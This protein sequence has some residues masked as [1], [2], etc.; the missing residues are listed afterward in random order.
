[1]SRQTKPTPKEVVVAHALF[2]GD[3]P[4]TACRK[5]RY[6]ESTIKTRA[7]KIAKSE[8]VQRVLQQIAASIAPGELT[9]LG[10]GR[11]KQQLISAGKN[12]KNM[13]AWVRTVAEIEGNLGNH[14]NQELHLHA[15]RHEEISPEVAEMVAQA[16]RRAFSSEQEGNK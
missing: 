13:L 5:A 2:G 12:D 11:I 7:S 16:V 15:H 9:T 6:A 8:Q 1:M 14:P 3:T 4:V 10:R